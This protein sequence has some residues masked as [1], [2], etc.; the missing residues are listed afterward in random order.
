MTVNAE[1]VVHSA[2][3]RRCVRVCLACGEPLEPTLDFLGSLRCL[4]CR[5]EN[6]QLDPVYVAAW[7]ASEARV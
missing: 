5:E 4:E 1:T 2:P 3:D 6:A 7:Y